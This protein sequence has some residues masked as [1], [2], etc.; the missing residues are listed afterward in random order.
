[1]TAVL[2]R[3][4]EFIDD[5]TNAFHVVEESIDTSPRSVPNSNGRFTRTWI[6]EQGKYHGIISPRE[7]FTE[8]LSTICTKGGF[9]KVKPQLQKERK[10]FNGSDE[11]DN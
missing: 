3:K 10:I 1:M 2:V 4:F 8:Y 6:G 5:D 7:T 9:V 11:T